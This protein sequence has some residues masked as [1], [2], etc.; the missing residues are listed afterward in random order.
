[1]RAPAES[2]LHSIRPN[3]ASGV[4][5]WRGI[6]LAGVPAGILG[7][8][9]VRSQADAP[10]HP[11]W[12]I[13]IDVAVGLGFIISGMLASG[14][15]RERLL[16]GLVGFLWLLGS[17]FPA[18]RLTHQAAL[19]IALLAFPSGK[20][21]GVLRWTLAGLA[22]TLAFGLIPQPGIAVIFAAIGLTAASASAVGRF[23]AASAITLGVVLTGSW[24]LSRG[25][26]VG[27]DPQLAVVAYQLT[28]LMIAVAFPIAAREA[29]TSRA[30][31][32]DRILGEETTLGLAGLG[33]VLADALRD[34]TI[35]VR[36]P[37][38]GSASP[39]NRLEVSDAGSLIAVIDYSA[40]GLDDPA[41]SDAVSS[42]VRIAVRR[43]LLERELQAQLLD[44]ESARAR[45]LSAADRQ[46]ELTAHRL[47]TDVVPPIRQAT[48]NLDEAAMGLEDGEA[49]EA[50]E[51]VIRELKT[52]QTEVM[53]LA[54][55]VPPRRL[56]DGRLVDA[57]RAMTQRSGIPFEVTAAPIDS[58]VDTET[59][60]FYVCS[61]AL[62]NA[63]KH[64][65][66][67][68][69]EVTLAEQADL[70]TLRVSDDGLGGADPSGTGLQ[71]LADRVASRGGRLRVD[72]PPGAGTT[73]MATLPR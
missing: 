26:A 69:I 45:V 60:L 27:Y 35:Q 20:L 13:A 52:A 68:R 55:G 6:A 59:T 12:L 24:W 33:A 47:R 34:P 66:A 46:R 8:F 43:E 57:I 53:G 73:I 40:P 70:I 11:A 65:G 67:R 64:A 9:A 58:D 54:S 22:V 1:M 3:E 10:G 36:R 23:P 39:R 61:E 51:V 32:A 44:L 14:P 30:R 18:T 42:A 31:V 25:T 17:V 41:I 2:L 71:G 72:S 56:G 5:G 62:A 19:A 29:I 15:A 21:S 38:D 7:V 49:A 63:V 37:D 50:L 16:V 48:S 28:L 4:S